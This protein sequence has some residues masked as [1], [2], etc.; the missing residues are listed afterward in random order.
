MKVALDWFTDAMLK[1]VPGADAAATAIKGL[2]IAAGFLSKFDQAMDA[3]IDKMTDVSWGAN[4]MGSV[5]SA[6]M[7]EK[8]K[9]EATPHV[10]ARGSKIEIKLDARGETPD[11]IARKL[12]DAMGKALTRPMTSTYAPAKGY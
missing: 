7:G 1:F 6:Y 2:A 12:F 10:D 8:P 5:K 9:V 3:P 4:A 11:R